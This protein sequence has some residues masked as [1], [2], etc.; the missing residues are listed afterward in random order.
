MICIPT[1]HLGMCLR[2]LAGQEQYARRSEIAKQLLI[3]PMS[4]HVLFRKQT[5][6]PA[7]LSSALAAAR[8]EIACI[9][10]LMSNAYSCYKCNSK[11]LEF[12]Q[13]VIISLLTPYALA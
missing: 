13:A 5:R 6:A 7:S 12:G 2:V 1:F 11:D 10:P 3:M 4:F 9:S 8:L